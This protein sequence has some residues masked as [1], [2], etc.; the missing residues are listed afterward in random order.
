[1]KTLKLGT[2]VRTIN[3]EPRKCEWFLLCEN[4][5]T[6]TLRHEIL[7]SVP[8]CDRCRAKNAR[9]EADVQRMG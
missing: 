7:G 6:G 4:P 5:A 9:L 8:V 2:K 1:M 3:L